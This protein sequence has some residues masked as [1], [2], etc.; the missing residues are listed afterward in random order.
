MTLFKKPCD[1]SKMNKEDPEELL[2]RRAKFLIYKKL[3]EADLM[4]SHRSPPSLLFLRMKIFRL[5]VMVGNGLTNLRRSIV[6]TIRFVG[7]KHSQ[8]GVKAFKKMF[9]GGATTRLPR[10]IFT[11]EV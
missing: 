8:G 5:K 6:S 4:I 11:L 10:P 1:Y 9:H 3:Q 7:K 2:H